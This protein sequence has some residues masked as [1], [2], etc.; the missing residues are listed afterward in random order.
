MAAVVGRDEEWSKNQELIEEKA[1]HFSLRALTIFCVRRLHRVLFALPLALLKAA[2]LEQ[3]ELERAS[4]LRIKGALKTVLLRKA[5]Q[6]RVARTRKR[7]EST[8]AIQQWYRDQQDRILRN[9]LA[10]QRLAEERLRA[11][12]IIQ[13]Q[14]RRRLAFLQLLELR[15]RR[16]DLIALR[17]AKATTLCRWGRV[18]VAK[19][20]V[21]KRRDEFDEEVRRALV[22][23]IWASTKIAAG[24][25]GKQGRNE[26][27]ARR[28]VRAQRWKALWSE[29][30]QRPFFYNKDTGETSWVKPRCL[31]DLE[32]KPIC[33]NCSN[34]L[35][36]FDCSQCQEFFC[37]Q[38]FEAVHSGGKRR[39]HAWKSVYDFYGRRKDLSQEPGTI[40]V[41]S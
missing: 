5:I 24:W 32:P 9:L 41:T 12:V 6:L 39:G 27:A 38:C 15:Q 36:E 1:F 22:L 18:C 10:A 33:S 8:L 26:A 16:D 3:Q 7:L 2:F 35:A 40:K 37:T 17:E 4:A 20:R 13:R 34:F 25:R 23:K 14:M 11:S 28:I 31:L 30:E 19:V 29:E 21:Q